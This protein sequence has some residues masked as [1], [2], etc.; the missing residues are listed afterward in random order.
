MRNPASRG[1]TSAEPIDYLKTQRRDPNDVAGGV[2][3]E[4]EPPVGTE[5]DRSRTT[6][7]V[8]AVVPAERKGQHGAGCRT[9]GRRRAWQRQTRGRVHGDGH[10]ACSRPGSDDPVKRNDR[11]PLPWIGPHGGLEVDTERRVADEERVSIRGDSRAARNRYD[12]RV[13]QVCAR[14]TGEAPVVAGANGEKLLATRHGPRVV[15]REL[16][17]EAPVVAART[18]QGSR[19]AQALNDGRSARGSVELENGSADQRA[20]VW[21]ATVCK[22]NVAL[23]A[24]IGYVNGAVVRDVDALGPVKHRRALGRVR[25]GSVGRCGRCRN[26]E[27][28]SQGAPKEN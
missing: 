16:E 17:A 23:A 12:I 5:G 8:L 1:V 7:L 21:R 19:V 9:G 26:S 22:A 6:V 2:I 27:R 15:F 3:G 25:S 18:T 4:K 11:S 20:T 24:P 28:R 14:A 13:G 10:E